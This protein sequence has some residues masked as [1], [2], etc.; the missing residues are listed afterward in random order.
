M[1]THTHTYEHTDYTKLNLHTKWA[2]ETETDEN[3]I[4]YL[5]TC[6]GV[7]THACLIVGT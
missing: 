6:A 1:H 2:A 5:C 3:K 4:L 7:W